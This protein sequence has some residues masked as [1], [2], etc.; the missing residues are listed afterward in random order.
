MITIRTD[1]RKIKPGDT[2]VAVKCAVNDGHK[3][4]DK[5][6]EKGATKIIAEEGTYSVETEIVSDSRKHLEDLLKTTYSYVFDKIKLIGITGTNGKT[7]TAYMIHDALNKLNKK[8]AYIGTIGYYINEKICSLPNT[9]PDLA[10]LYELIVDAYD[11]G[12]EYVVLEASSQGLDGGRLNGLEFDYALFTNLTQDH[13]DHHK[14]M[15]NYALAKKMLFDALKENGTAILNYDDEAKHYYVKPNTIYYGFNGGDYQIT[16]FKLTPHSSTFTYKNNSIDTTININIP[17]KHN[18]YNALT[19]L[20]VLD[21]LGES[22]ENIIS[23]MPKLKA[24]DGRMDTIKYNNNSIIIDYAHTPDA[25]EKIINTAREMT[26]GNIYTVFGCTGD[27]DRTKRPIMTEIVTNLS[28]QAIITIDDLHNEDANQIV[29]DMLEGLKNTN[30]E[31]CLDRE[32]AIEIGINYLKDNDVLLILGKGHEEFIIVKDEKIPFNDKK[33][34]SK[35]I[36]EKL[37]VTN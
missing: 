18:I 4:I 16:D 24:P 21:I 36:D 14:T 20:I 37:K 27:R 30:Y 22:K 32:K 11:N 6:I 31:I 3:Y 19:T 33:V 35:I 15:E 5:A 7:T 9:S 8:C 13:L 10:D 26:T 23:V 25:V 17:G 1:S 2:F 12:C 28:T 34:A 29:S